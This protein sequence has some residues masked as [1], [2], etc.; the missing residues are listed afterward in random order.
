MVVS[1][2]ATLAGTLGLRP[3][4]FFICKQMFANNA[5]YFHYWEVELW[6]LR[7]KI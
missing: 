3:H 1:L 5:S 4:P 7:Q 2:S 6:Q